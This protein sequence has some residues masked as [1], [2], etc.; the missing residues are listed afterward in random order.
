[1]RARVRVWV[2]VRIRVRVRQA[3]APLVYMQE[4]S[5]LCLQGHAQ[6]WA[7]LVLHKTGRNATRVRVSCHA[8][9]VR[10]S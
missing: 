2:R 5:W 8:T 6:A 3:R 7:P 10:V 4:G 1:M 9:R